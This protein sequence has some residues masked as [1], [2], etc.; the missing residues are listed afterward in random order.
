V[1]KSTSFTTESG[2]NVG[3][4]F[5]FNSTD[6]IGRLITPTGIT[7]E[8]IFYNSNNYEF[9]INSNYVIHEYD[10]GSNINITMYDLSLNPIKTVTTNEHSLIDFSLY[11]DRLLLIT[12][13]AGETYNYLI[14][15]DTT[16]VVVLGLTNS[17]IAN[18][19]ITWY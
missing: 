6:K 2:L 16:T 15:T 14:T 8:V 4:L 17:Q 1:Y 11:D 9:R 10:D 3:N 12:S 18:D 5:I 7:E 19:Y 13:S